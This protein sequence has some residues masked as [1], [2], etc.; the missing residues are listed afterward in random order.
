MEEWKFDSLIE[1]F[2]S[3]LTEGSKREYLM[4]FSDLQIQIEGWFRGELMNYL[5]NENVKITVYNREVP[6]NNNNRRKVDL[7]IEVNNEFYW[8]ELKHILVGCQR[9]NTYSFRSYFSDN[10]YIH[11]DIKKLY[12]IDK[13]NKRQLGYSV[14]FIST[15]YSC[16]K[17]KYP[18]FEEIDSRERLRERY[19]EVKENKT[20]IQQSI[21]HVSCNY[22]SITHFGYLLLEIKMNNDDVN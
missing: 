21:S 11:N 14:A 20:D 15:N 18:N 3:S 6:I 12:D 16:D 13:S 19:E 17:C 1:K 7:R 9:N 4:L 5:K 22:D 10:T 8:I 2:Y